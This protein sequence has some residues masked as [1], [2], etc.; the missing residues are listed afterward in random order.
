MPAALPC[1]ERVTEVDVVSV[2]EAV[3]SKPK[4]QGQN[5]HQ[6]DEEVAVAATLHLHL[7]K[8]RS[9]PALTNLALNIPLPP[10]A[11]G[12]YRFPLRRNR[13]CRGGNSAGQPHDADDCTCSAQPRLAL[14]PFRS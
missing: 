5:C 8:L 2:S 6:Y 7:A 1:L 9:L 11:R 10:R 13:R 4:G 14:G 3:R 12:E